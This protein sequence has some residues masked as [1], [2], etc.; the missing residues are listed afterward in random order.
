L[1]DFAESRISECRGKGKGCLQQEKF[2]IR[3]Q[4]FAGKGWATGF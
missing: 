1:I 2:I 4:I 3:A